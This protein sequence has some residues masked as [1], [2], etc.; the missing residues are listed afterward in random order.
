MREINK[1]TH[2]QKTH[3]QKNTQTKKHTNKK[4]HKQKN[5]QT[6]KHTNVFFVAT[7]F[8][9]LKYKIIKFILIQN[10]FT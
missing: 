5:T 7:N 6:K 3:K 4:T 2:K 9:I 10:Q 8:I 1:K